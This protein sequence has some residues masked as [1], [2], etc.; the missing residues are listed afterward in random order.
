MSV[1]TILSK[2]AIFVKKKAFFRWFRRQRGIAYL[3]KP[4]RDGWKEASECCTSGQFSRA[5]SNQAPSSR[6]SNTFSSSACGAIKSNYLSMK[7]DYRTFRYRNCCS[8]SHWAPF[9]NNNQQATWATIVPTLY[10]F[11]DSLVQLCGNSLASRKWEVRLRKQLR[12]WQ[13]WL[14]GGFRD[15]L[16]RA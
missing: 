11:Q 15:Q 14:D 5:L 8:S 12:K 10:S 1:L 13:R 4:G 7:W 3:A 16:Q 6:F 2:M 9:V